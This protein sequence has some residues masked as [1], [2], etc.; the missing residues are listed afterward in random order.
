[1]WPIAGLDGA[2][3]A[4]L[5]ADRRSETAA[6]AGEEDTV[7]LSVVVAAIAAI[8]IE[9]RDRR[10]GETLDLAGGGL[11][12]VPVPRVRPPAGP[13][14]GSGIAGQRHH[15]EDEAA[16]V[17]HGDADLDAELV[18]LVR[19]AFGEAFDLGSVQGIELAGVVSLL[20]E[21]PVDQDEGAGK[22]RRQ[23]LIAGELAPDV[24]R[25][26]AEKGLE[27][28]D[29]ALGAVVLAGMQIGAG[30]CAAPACRAAHSFGAG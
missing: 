2:A 8:D 11:Q 23:G 19:L 12:G 28:L 22:V 21:Q 10:A 24:A 18:L 13:R 15:A 25:H 4:Q 27:P 20:G 5:L 17:G 6:L 16:P 14:T 7:L 1:M 26:P 9:P 30:P 3:T 29:F